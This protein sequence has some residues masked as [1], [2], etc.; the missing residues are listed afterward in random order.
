MG[1]T[2]KKMKFKSPTYGELVLKE[3]VHIMG[4][5]VKEKPEAEYRF[6]VGTDSMPSGDKTV[7]AMAV[8][9]HREGNGCIYFYSQKLETRPL[10]FVSRIY[11]EATYSHD[12]ARM[13]K[14][15]DKFQELDMLCQDNSNMTIHIDTGENGKTK[16]V[17][18]GIMGMVRVRGYGCEAKP[19][20]FVANC[21][22]DRHSKY[23][24]G[25]TIAFSM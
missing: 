19:Y 21:I 2:Q 5:F 23:L 15:E 3:V 24:A 4:Q 16:E 7:F 9:V 11:Q 10:D 22:A 6:Y 18:A 8:A 13:L 14:K 12:L 20:S 25:D 1:I 17:L